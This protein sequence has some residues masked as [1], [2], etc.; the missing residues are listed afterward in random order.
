MRK[1]Q[2]QHLPSYFDRYI[3]LV[4]DLAI[5]DAL[6]Q[7]GNTYLQAEKPTLINIGDAVY[8]PG[9]WTVKDILQH[10]IDTERIFSYRALRFARHD[11]TP[12]PGF[13][14]NAYANSVDTSNRTVDD[15]LLE[16]AAVR[17]STLG[18]FLGFDE[19]QLNREGTASSNKISVA[20]LG[21]TIVGHV[22]HHTNV[23]KE[24]YYPLIYNH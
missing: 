15:L 7:Y 2:L 18:L 13:E 23:L 24:R 16:F 17:Q 14:E 8:A 20:A 6:H 1:S 22:I 19:G 9:K 4:P 10:I 12:L 11:D 3:D 5:I 21:F